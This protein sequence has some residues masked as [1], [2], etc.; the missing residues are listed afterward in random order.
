MDTLF[1]E[2]PIGSEIPE[3]AVLEPDVVRVPVS[4]LNEPAQ[5]IRG[6][7]RPSEP[8][9]QP[10][11]PQGRSG[12]PASR[13]TMPAAHAERKT[14]FEIERHMDA[15]S[16]DVLSLEVDRRPST[17]AVPSAEAGP[18]PAKPMPARRAKAA[19]KD[20]QGAILTL[21]WEI[22]R[23]SVK[24]LADRLKHVRREF[25][26]N[27]TVG[28]AALSMRVVL[29]YIVKRMSRA[30]P[31]SIR[32]LLEVADFLDKSVMLSEQD[33]LKAFHHILTRYEKYKSLVR[34]AEGL[35]DP[36]P[37]ILDELKIRDPKAFSKIVEAQAKMLVRAG[38][39]LARALGSTDEPENLIRSFRFL[40]NQSANRI[41]EQTH[42]NSREKKPPAQRGNRGGRKDSG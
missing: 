33:P 17:P 13:G 37:T 39:S 20:L 18:P 24:A 5:Q 12:Q 11:S 28:F 4:E 36:R 8:R 42:A 21:E 41:L 29:D 14:T 19:L 9:A 31:E 26:E 10:V 7:F 23:R 25:E 2:E 35:P 16:S 6:E 3:T 22:S 30:H 1:V 15:L 32:F 38:Y 34:R 27:V 40:V